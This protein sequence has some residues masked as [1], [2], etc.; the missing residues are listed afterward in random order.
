MTMTRKGSPGYGFGSSVRSPI[1]A[2][3]KLT[4]PA[5]GSYSLPVK[6]G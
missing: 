5:P 4:G 6:V 3:G 2:K 1:C